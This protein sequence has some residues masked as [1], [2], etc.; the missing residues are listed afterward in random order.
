V[1]EPDEVLGTRG[2]HARRKGDAT[3]RSLR[4]P[5]YRRFFTG[6]AVSNVGT[7]MQ[8][9]AQDWLVLQLS[10]GDAVALGITTA[11]QFA[12][13]VLLS[14]AGGLLAD[15]Y[16]K[17]GLLFATNAFLG[18][19]ALVLG[20]LVLSDVAHVW[21]VYLLASALGVGAALDAPTRNAFVVEM[22]GRDDLP[23]AVGL[24][25]ASFNGARIVGPAVAGL[26][27][28]AFG[29]DTGWVFLLNAA[30]FVAPLI[31]LQRMDTALLLPADPAP[32]KKGQVR[33]GV[34]YV[35]G[36]PDLVAVLGV[37]FFAG[38]FGMN[39]QITNA[40]MATQEFHKG[41]GEYGLLG[42]SFALGSL[43][44][45]LFAARRPQVR[46][47]LVIGSAIAFGRWE[48]V[49]GMMPSYGW[50][51]LA[52][53]LAGVA[54]LT[55]M[56]AANSM[57]QLSVAPAM[58]GRVISLY[59]MVL[60]G[61]TPVGAPVV[62]WVAQQYGPRW[63]LIVGGAVTAAAA[64]VAGLLLARRA[65]LTVRARVFPRPRMSLEYPPAVTEPVA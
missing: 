44:G 12:P 54:A 30:S 15:R 50:Y 38:M 34:R 49:V 23:N 11:L 61:G 6:M 5:N 60:F 64:A 18:L 21:H 51:A 10:G 36:R 45:S 19:V 46:I 53:P 40:L 43:A 17:R 22:V 16:S 7:W 33:E 48:F 2:R 4:V 59:I 1:T 56:T 39:F 27:I 42:S 14:P 20:L 35:R 41:A 31:A 24:N 47:R 58:R 37:V 55:T 13:V 32:K 57:L 28:E 8:R 65:K 63:S 62:G 52:L 25:S 29:G 3:F 26:L 9:V